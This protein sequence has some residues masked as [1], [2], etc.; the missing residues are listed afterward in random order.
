MK[1]QPIQSATSLPPSPD[2]ERRSRMIRYAVTMGIRMVCFLVAILIPV[3]WWTLIP[4]AGAIFLPYFAVV[5]A[6]T[7][8]NPNVTPV[9]RPGGLIHVVAPRDPGSDA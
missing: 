6:N 1:K 9:A 5:M 8:N 2:D 3:S 7:A 4:L